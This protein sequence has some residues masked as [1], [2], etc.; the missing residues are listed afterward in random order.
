LQRLQN[1]AFRRGRESGHKRDHFDVNR[2]VSIVTR[3]IAKPLQWNPS[4][5]F[6]NFDRHS[7]GADAMVQPPQTARPPS[8]G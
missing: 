7:I 1:R 8:E 2:V 3:S 6:L 4:L 5:N